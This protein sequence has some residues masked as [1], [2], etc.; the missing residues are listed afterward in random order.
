VPIADRKHQ[1]YTLDSEASRLMG[2]SGRMAGLHV[3]V[4]HGGQSENVE[5]GVH[6]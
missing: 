6:K 2:S 1:T 3:T 4:L 5:F